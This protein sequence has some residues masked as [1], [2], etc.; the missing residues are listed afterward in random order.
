MQSEEDEANEIR[1]GKSASYEFERSE[2]VL[3]TVQAGSIISAQ[4][5]RFHRAEVV[6]C[7]RSGFRSCA[8]SSEHVVEHSSELN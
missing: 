2:N 5:L 6:P 4:W 8:R 7:G 1:I 3:D